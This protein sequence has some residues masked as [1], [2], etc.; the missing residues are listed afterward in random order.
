M[1]NI[2]DSFEQGM[3]IGDNMGRQIRDS[4]AYQDGG[5]G[6]VEEQA[7]RTGDF[8]SAEAGQTMARRR[9]VFQDEERQAAYERMETVAPWARNVVRAATGLAST[10]PA[11]ARAFLENNQQRFLDFGLTPEHVQAGIAGLT[12]PDPAVREQWRTQIDAAF[13][14]HQNPE[15][16]I[17]PLTGR[18]QAT[19]PDG[20][21]TE[22]AEAP[23]A[24]LLRRGAI[25]EI[26]LNERNARAPYSASNVLGD[27]TYSVLSEAEV[28]AMGL[29]PG[30]YQRNNATGQ[31]TPLGRQRGQYTD[32]A[33]SSA[34]F[35]SRMAASHQTL[36]RLEAMFTDPAGVFLAQGG[37]G[38]ENERLVRQAQREFVNAILRR[39]SGAVIADS[40]FASAA[41]QYFPQ[42]GDTAAVIAQKRA[43]RQRSIQGLINASQ[44]AYDEWYGEGS[45][46]EPPP[47]P[48]AGSGT[49]SVI[50]AMVGAVGAPR[51]EL[52]RPRE[53]PA[54]E[55]SAMTPEERDRIIQI[56]ARQPQQ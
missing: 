25:A 16:Q 4:R 23:G 18:A 40:E 8:E 46:A 29:P 35:A 50:G 3:G 30:T 45:G 42:P 22:G 17:N 37:M 53:I 56:L 54:E 21:F 26:E 48:A 41:Q 1:S 9:R 55:W 15:W 43:A 49:G 14:Q 13:T 38:T 5:Y 2:W 10:D 51:A 6:A 24:E 44:G 11:R 31:V 52:E 7:A 47:A 33:A 32:A 39:E 12:D 20:T 28:E 19:N 27:G 36:E 34:Q